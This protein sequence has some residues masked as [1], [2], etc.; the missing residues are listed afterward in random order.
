MTQLEKIY[1]ACV[2]SF[3]N[4]IKTL[5]K[6]I[7]INS[8]SYDALQILKIN[9]SLIQTKSYYDT[10]PLFMFQQK[11][12]LLQMYH[13]LTNIQT[14]QS[15]IQILALCD[16][17][18]SSKPIYFD[19]TKSVFASKHDVAW[20]QSNKHL[21]V[22]MNIDFIS[23]PPPDLFLNM[24]VL[25]NCVVYIRSNHSLHCLKEILTSSTLKK[26][27]IYTKDLLLEPIIQL[28][29]SY[30]FDITIITQQ[31]YHLNYLSSPIPS[32]IHL[33][34]NEPFKKYCYIPKHVFTL[35]INA[36][37]DI[38]NLNNLFNQYQFTSLILSLYV[39]NPTFIDLS[40]LTTLQSLVCTSHTPLTITLPTTI[41]SLT[42]APNIHITNQDLLPLLSLKD[43][44]SSINIPPTLTSLTMYIPTQVEIQI[45]T[46]ISCNLCELSLENKFISTIKQND[47]PCLTALT[48]FYCNS[49]HLNHLTT[50]KNLDCN[51]TIPLSL[52]PFL[53]HL[54]ATLIKVPQ[55]P[56]TL[57]SLILQ[58]PINLPILPLQLTF[59]SLHNTTEPKLSSLTKLLNL[60]LIN[61]PFS[62][63][64]LPTSI[65]NL[66][67]NRIA[68]LCFDLVDF[69]SLKYLAIDFVTS[70][71]FLLVPTSL[72]K[73]SLDHVDLFDWNIPSVPLQTLLIANCDTS[74][75]DTKS[76]E[77]C[78]C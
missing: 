45:N 42:T 38:I 9:N 25:R 61:T 31:S 3:F 4:D 23:T 75:L 11:N 15:Q 12:Q 67:V 54:Y 55:L 52:P 29:S 10:Y 57:Q 30:S 34:V 74:L 60:S 56:L 53:T 2:Y 47:V 16:F 27:I 62:T 65:T 69:I 32:N 20:F 17:T 58:T 51:K 66:Y 40:N 59:L 26:L 36:S 39:S 71:D 63:N 35:E 18:T 33:F 73:L 76:K 6:I 44:K 43:D 7:L 46:L 68:P 21:I 22:Q 24:V 28:I 72:C 50:I 78:I 49:Q 70:L 13:L 41:T 5:H 19:I 8:K 77:I 37:S 1:M 48:L 14:I 64:E